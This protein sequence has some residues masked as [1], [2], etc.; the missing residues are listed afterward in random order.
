MNSTKDENMEK[1]EEKVTKQEEVNNHEEQSETPAS[2]KTTE[3]S[4]ELSPEEKL[5]QSLD[6]A[7]KRIAEIQDKYLRL[8]AEFDNYRKRTIK[9]KSEIIKNAAEKTITAIL[10]VLD[11]MERAIANMQK[12]ED[13]KAWLE[14]VELINNKFLKILSQEGLNKIE[15]EGADFDTDYHEAIAMIPA[16]NEEQKGKVLVCVQTGYK[17]ND[18]VIRHAKVAV[19]Q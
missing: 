2:E 17:L 4:K 14:G 5:Q 19:A 16:P 13:A 3:E 6:E 11:D 18:K 7:E 15:T 1:Q 8:S 10:P 9:E 12:S